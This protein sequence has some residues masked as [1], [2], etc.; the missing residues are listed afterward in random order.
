MDTMAQLRR[1]LAVLKHLEAWLLLAL[2]MVCINFTMPTSARL[3][4]AAE[5]LRSH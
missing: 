1:L 3:Y 4:L 2:L 5:E